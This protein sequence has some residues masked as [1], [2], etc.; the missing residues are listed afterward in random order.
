MA[1]QDPTANNDFSGNSPLLQVRYVMHL[2]INKLFFILL[3]IAGVA[4]FAAEPQQLD[5]LPDQLEPALHRFYIKLGETST[6]RA[7]KVPVLVLE[8]QKPGKTL[9]LTAAIHGDELNGIRVIHRLMGDLQPG[10]LKGRIIAVPGVN[11][12]G[13]V[14]NNRHFMGSSGGGYMVDLNRSFPGTPGTGDA[15]QRFL[16]G[17]WSKIV[18]GRADLGIDLHTQTRGT[19]YPLFVFADFRNPRVRAMATALMPDVIK[20]DPGE[21][22]TLETALVAEGIPAVT[23]EI[24]EP[25]R[26]Q[27]QLIERAVE[28]IKNV[29]RLEGM[30]TGPVVRPAV[31][32][33]TGRRFTNVEARR[34]GIA[35]IDVALKDRV[36]KGKLVA[37]LFDPFGQEIDRYYA[38]H[39][40]YVLSI[41]TDP[42]RE[43]GALLVR[44][45]E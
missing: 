44:I 35:V 11:Q 2:I 41:A 40:G 21:T 8:G 36:A 20:N 14:A 38:P 7:L 19:S 10:D 23:F 17:F 27:K 3:W 29:M 25:K 26:F 33:L 24:G 9:L 1:A 43:P 4:A 13:M 15:A 45:L 39:S 18:E 28:G 16:S 32:P 6:A 37:R 31:P 34:G 30:L 22:G 12:P 42:L 5:N